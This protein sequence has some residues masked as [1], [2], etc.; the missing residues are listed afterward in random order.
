MIKIRKINRSNDD[1]MPAT[2]MAD[3]LL[4]ALYVLILT[5]LISSV[6]AHY[7]VFVQIAFASLSHIYMCIRFKHT[8]SW[9]KIILI[10]MCYGSVLSLNLLLVGNITVKMIIYAVWIM[11]SIAMLLYYFKFPTSI[12]YI[13][14]IFAIAFIALR[15]AI[16]GDPNLVTVNSRN[17]LGFY[18]A[19]YGLPYY[20]HCY[21]EHTTPNVAFPIITLIVS[22]RAVG[23]GGIVLSLILMMGWLIEYINKTKHKFFVGSIIMIIGIC[24]LVA[25]SEPGFIEKYFSRFKE[26]GVQSSVRSGLIIEYL[27]SLSNVSNFLHGTNLDSLSLI[28]FWG[29]STHNSYLNVHARMGI[30]AFF[31]IFMIMKGF[32]SLFRNRAGFLTFFYIAILIKAFID[33]DFP[34]TPVG[35]DI[36]VYLL[37]LIAFANK[38]AR[39]HNL[40]RSDCIIGNTKDAEA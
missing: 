5:S 38:E 7:C 36:Y 15:W 13:I 29:N 40:V 21:K 32:M 35:G 25:A 27:D 14:F 30:F 19:I 22:I 24:L 8:N 16:V 17:Y 39:R 11:P 9:N 33:S 12:L 3:V 31:Y 4:L 26:R 2:L 28:R 10:L 1:R 23:R 18:L 6:M 34:G 20:Y 37:I